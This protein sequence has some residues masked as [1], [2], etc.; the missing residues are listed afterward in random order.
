[1]SYSKK[2]KSNFFNIDPYLKGKGQYSR[3]GEKELVLLGKP[4]VIPYN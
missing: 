1:M 3:T 2:L 4:K